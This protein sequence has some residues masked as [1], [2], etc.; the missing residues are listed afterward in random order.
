MNAIPSY[1]YPAALIAF[2]MVSWPLMAKVSNTPAAWVTTLVLIGT[3]IGNL[4]VGWND[5][6][7]SPLFSMWSFGIM[8][9]A[10]VV[11]GIA[12]YYYG[13][14]SADPTIPTWALVASINILMVGFAALLGSAISWSFP[15]LRQFA[16]IILAGIGIYLI[17]GK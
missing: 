11:N 17:A 3:L 10:G 2:G 8:M 14:K 5:M 15:T 9:V 12:V 4:V 13:A 7:K 16:G 6:V 1:L